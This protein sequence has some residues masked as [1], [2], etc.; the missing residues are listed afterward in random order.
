MLPFI[1][2]AQIDT[3]R[4]RFQPGVGSYPM[5][6]S[7]PSRI[8]QTIC[9][10]MIV[11]DEF[12]GLT[13]HKRMDIDSSVAVTNTGLNTLLIIEYGAF[14]TGVKKES[15]VAPKGF[16]LSQ[17]Y[18]NPFNP[19]TQIRFSTDKSA[20]IEL[21]VFDVLGREITT[22][23]SNEMTPGEYSA[24][25]DGKNKYGQQM[26]SGVYYVR[27]TASVRDQGGSGSGVFTSTRK[28]LMMK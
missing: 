13:V 2:Y 24:T 5:I 12:G 1:A 10:S 28:M 21:K 18:P 6:L 26:P 27:M 14:P 9:D 3:F 4:I 19:T 16:A 8:I 20:R 7:W 17:N 15:P 22:L 11:M 23:L 25:W